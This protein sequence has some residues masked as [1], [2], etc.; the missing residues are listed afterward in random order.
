[1]STS[2]KSLVSVIMPVFDERESIEHC[3][4]S[5]LG[6]ITDGFE[7]EVLVVDGNSADGTAEMVAAIAAGDDR[8]RL[9]HNPIRK[10]PV[11]FNLGL[12]AARGEY[13]CILGAHTVYPPDYISVCLQELRRRGAVGCSGRIVT[14]PAEN[15]LQA[16][17][18]AWTFG[19]S[20]ASSPT[21]VRTRIE[22]FADTI[23]YPVFQKEPLLEVGGYDEAL[24][25]NQDNDMNQR[26]RARGYRLYLTSRTK[27]QYRARPTLAALWKYAFRTGWWNGVSLRHKPA[28]MSLR[29]LVPS[30]FVLTLLGLIGIGLLSQL[31]TGQ[32]ASGAITALLLVLGA[33][34]AVG[35]AAA[36]TTAVRDRAFGPLLLPPVFLAFHIA[37]GFGALV[38]ITTKTEGFQAAQAPE[39]KTE[40]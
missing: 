28:S 10:T 21:S 39:L 5:V 25:R 33:H 2:I 32:F 19:S 26:L 23:P 37:Y 36:C 1:M 17:L 11:A 15:T 3:L 31:V 30:L 35:I 27:C 4:R 12:H 29:H 8:I 16:R 18:S 9:I 34:L 14:V 38:G 20:F 7:L 6:Q 22:G 40:G 24:E 13:V